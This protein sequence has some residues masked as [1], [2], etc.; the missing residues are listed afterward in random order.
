MNGKRA[1]RAVKYAG[2]GM[3]L[4]TIAGVAGCVRVSGGMWYVRSAPAPEI[5][6]AR[7]AAP[8]ETPEAEEA[9]EPADE[10]EPAEQPVPQITQEDAPSPLVEAARHLGVTPSALSKALTRARK[11]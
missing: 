1:A 7:E 10:E 2:A 3:L 4:L 5:Q 6:V 9:T 8:A 11:A